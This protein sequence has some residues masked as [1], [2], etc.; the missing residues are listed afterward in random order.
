[1]VYH[2][3]IA[4]DP[5]VRYLKCKKILYFHNI[6]TPEMLIGDDALGLRERCSVGMYDLWGTHLYFDY[7]ITSSNYSKEI[8]IKHN[9]SADRV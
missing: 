4:M 8:L 7:A 6:T 5:M 2:M 3:S 1:M 9:W